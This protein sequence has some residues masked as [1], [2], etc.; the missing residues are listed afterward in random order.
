MNFVEMLR[1][2]FRS[3]A[4]KFVVICIL[5]L[6]L[7]IPLLFAYALIHE[8]QGFAGN[9]QSEIG[10]LWGGQQTLRGPVLAVPVIH[11]RRVKRGKETEERQVRRIA[12]FLPEDLKIRPVVRTEMR[13]RGIFTIP[14]YRSEI[15]VEGRFIA[16]ETRQY[17][18]PSS[19]L[20][21][22]E[23]V[24]AVT[25]SDVRGIKKTASVRLGNGSEV[26]FRSGL[27]VSGVHNRTFGIHIPLGADTARNGVAF[28]FKL[29]VNGSSRMWFVP[30]GGETLIEMKSDWPHPSFTG[31]FLPESRQISARGF[32]AQWRIPRLA[33][34]QGQALEQ[35]GLSNLLQRTAFGV[36]FFQPV[37][38]YSLAERALKY[39]LGFIAIVFLSVFIAEMNSAR[40]VHWIQYLF[41]GFS[42]IIFYL[43][44]IGTAE[45]IGFDRGYLAAAA[46]TS[47]LIGSYIATV[48]SSWR[49]GALLLSV[50]SLVY[51]L[52][53]LLLR[54]E[55]YALLIG[56]ISAFVL[57]AIVMFATRNVDWSL[58]RDAQDRAAE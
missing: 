48:T 22:N 1:R 55:D 7:S 39:A 9:A 56:S 49:N 2:L 42:M 26:K 38:F 32:E 11:T 10:N 50:I 28:S 34:G 4:F 3:P 21:W 23:A 18:S 44:L 24:M 41:V 14:V 15:A 43:V 46:A 30:A 36:N 19:E 12:I 20:L 29:D 54:V 52:L 47:V 45:H 31:A 8:R 37:K 51:G 17:A 53:Y 6:L 27:G 40:R 5:V 57:L 16:P 58:S 35:D 33:R 13:S 25:L